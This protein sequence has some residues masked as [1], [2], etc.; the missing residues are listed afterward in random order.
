MTE[1]TKENLCINTVIANSS[2][3]PFNIILTIK[4][5]DELFENILNLHESKN[6]EN[7]NNLHRS[8]IPT[9]QSNYDDKKSYIYS[10]RIISNKVIVPI[11]NVKDEEIKMVE[12]KQEEKPEK[13]PKFGRKRGRSGIEG[14]HNKFSDDNLRRKCKHIILNEILMFINDKINKIYDGDLG[15]GILIKKLYTLNHNQKAN[16]VIKYNK[17]FLYKTLEDIFS[18]ISRKV[19]SYPKDYNKNLIKS[20]KNEKD[21]EK[22]KYFQNLFNLTFLQ[23][24]NHFNEKKICEE[25][26][27]MKNMSK[28]L[29]GYSEDQDYLDN[30]KLCFTNYESFINNTKSRKSRHEC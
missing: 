21:Y 14:K 2:K 5:K 1:Q 24:L 7:K 12:I 16:A 29:D 28:I 15:Q 17:E 25:L 19:T 11:N 20:L 23:C 27:G 22:K 13:K 26:V 6:P 3:S 8:E 18:D 10:T 30:L 4:N 9:D